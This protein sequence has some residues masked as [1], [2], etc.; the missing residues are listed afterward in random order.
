MINKYYK[1]GKSKNKYIAL[2]CTE[3][4]GS[5]SMKEMYFSNSFNDVLNFIKGS[6]YSM[7]GFVTYVR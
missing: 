1:I 3:Y 4:K 7:K 5:I 2:K 6:K